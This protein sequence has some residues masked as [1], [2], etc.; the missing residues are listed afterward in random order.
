MSF[1]LAALDRRVSAI[2][3]AQS[4]S[5]RFGRVTSVAG[6][7]AR[8][9]LPDGQGMVSY[10][11]STIQHRTLKDQDIKMPDIGEPVACLFSGQGCEQGVVLGAYY[12]GQETDP[13]VPASHDYHRYADGTEI[14]YD[15]EA[16]KLIARVQG[17]C[18][19]TCEGYAKITAKGEISAES[20]EASV[21]IRAAK[22]IQ[23]EAKNKIVL[24][25]PLIELAGFLKMTDM[26]GNPGQGELSG[27]FTVRDGGISVPDR[28]VSAGAVSLRGHCHENSGGPGIGGSPVGG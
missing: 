4:A 20:T 9:E 14:W 15:R 3:A 13:G 12:N 6:G 18:E 2:E 10:E 26:N 28:D 23:A 1:D 24:R 8:V 7:K 16:H 25:A 21:N 27:D 17:D 19:L 5:L 11:L 22:E